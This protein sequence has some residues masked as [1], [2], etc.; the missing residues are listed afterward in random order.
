[1][2]ATSAIALVAPAQAQSLESGWIPTDD[3]ATASPVSE[4]PAPKKARS[5]DRARVEVTPYIEAQ[6][7]LLVDVSG[8]GEVL[9]Y[10]T[11]AAGVDAAINTRRAEAQVNVRYERLIGYDDDVQGQDNISGLARGS[12]AITRNL[13]IEAG[14]IATRSR[15]DNRVG[16]PGTIL[17]NQDNVTQ[18]YSVYTGPTF[19]AQVGD[20]SVNA[21]YRA[22]YTKVEANDVGPLPPGQLAADLFDDS[23]SHSAMA[24]VGMQPGNLPFGWAVSAGWDREDASQLDQRFDAKYARADVTVP[25]T[26]TLAAVGGVGYEDISISE[27]DALRDALGNPIITPSGRFVTDPA[28]PRLIAYESDGLIWDAGVLWR[29]SNRTSLEA[30]YGRRYG[31][32]TYFGSFSYQPN[33]RLAA[34]ISVYDTVTG[35]GSSL[36]RSLI[37]LPTQFNSIRN[38]LSGD[39]GS[40]AFGAAGA[41]CF[42]N[43]LGSLRSAAFR[44]RGVAA[45]VVTNSGGW[46]SGLAIGYN[47][48]KF[49]TSGL[50]AQAQLDGLVDENYY[51]AG[52]L[53]RDLDRRSRFE[54]NVYGNWVDP[55]FSLASDV[56]NV[57]ANAAYYRQ[58]WRGLSAT[59]AVG[60]DSVKQEDFASDVTASALLGLRYSF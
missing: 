29:P 7:V 23:V 24:S 39:I 51:V 11:I 43:A 18:V 60:I 32:D 20:L 59:A 27:R 12:V 56:Y 48:Q 9:T 30:R 19:A 14:G 42:N 38:P 53:G 41:S 4:A 28:S 1:M 2:L 57:G 50:G 45:S 55:G 36:S 44:S 5:G 26:P 16:T 31:T 10:S 54:T 3:S 49:L 37:A 46:E 13:S 15:I 8:S 22:G 33:E 35:F 34:N 52:F 17:G 58:L 25:I 40:C 6:Q 47:Q 21:A